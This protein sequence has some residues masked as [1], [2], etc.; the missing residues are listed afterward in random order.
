ML[1]TRGMLGA[2]IQNADVDWNRRF[3][4]YGCCAAFARNDK[5]LKCVRYRAEGQA[6]RGRRGCRL[7]RIMLQKPRTLAADSQTSLFSTHDE[8]H[9][10]DAV[11]NRPAGSGVGRNASAPSRSTR[12]SAATSGTGKGVGGVGWI[13]AYTDGGS[14][15]NPGPAGYGV[16]VQASDGAKLAELSEFLGIATNNVAEYSALLAALQYALEQ[17][18]A[19][20]RVISDS[21][22]MVKQ[23]R[24]QYSVKSPDL[25]PLY[26]EARRRVA[27]LEA[28]AIEHVLRGKNKQADGL[29]NAAMDRGMKR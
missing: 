29:A 8:A 23:M 9:A 6:E 20:L 4:D 2:C 7:R 1:H 22:L 13:T 28:F 14:R 25:R 27:R 19:R 5:V 12:S 16:L 21:E 11:A 26:E 18:H 3:L 17:G 15:G 10:R 24:G